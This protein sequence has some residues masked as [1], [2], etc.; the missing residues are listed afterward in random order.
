MLPI[1]FL[2]WNKN[3]WL[4]VEDGVD[5]GEFGGGEREIGEATDAVGYLRH[6]AA[7]DDHRGDRRIFKNPCKRHLTESLTT[8]GGYLIQF[9]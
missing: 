6:W 8:H 4:Y 7:A 2:K 3:D 5:G 9:L 1:S